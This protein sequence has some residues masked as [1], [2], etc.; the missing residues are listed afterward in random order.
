[1]AGPRVPTSRRLARQ[2]LPQLLDLA[3]YPVDHRG[4]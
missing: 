4:G 3:G 1:M 2:V